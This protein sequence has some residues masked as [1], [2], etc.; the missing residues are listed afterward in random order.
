MTVRGTIRRASVEGGLWVLEADGG[1]TYSLRGGGSDAYRDG[2]RVEVV[3]EVDR[4]AVG[5]G[6]VG[7]TLVVKTIKPGR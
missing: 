2:A 4:A 6:M 5:I 1:K 7:E 3:G